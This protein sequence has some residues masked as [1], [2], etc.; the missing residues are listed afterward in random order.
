MQPEALVRRDLSVCR[1]WVVR[2]P[3]GY[4]MYFTWSVKDPEAAIPSG[5]RILAAF[6]R[7]LVRW[8]VDERSLVEPFDGRNYLAS[9]C[10]E[11]IPGGYRMYFTASR[12]MR[13]CDAIYVAESED[14]LRFGGEFR[15]VM[16]PAAGKPYARGCF[17]PFVTGSG[18]ARR[19]LFAGYGVDRRPQICVADG[20]GEWDFWD[21]RLLMGGFNHPD[22]SYG[23]YK[24]V[25]FE[26]W[27]YFVGK[28]AEERGSVYRMPC[29]EF[30]L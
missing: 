25:L 12:K 18:E 1:P 9:P 23:P 30:G 4:R 27:M 16:A 6:S 13:C 15:E 29:S 22:I 10:V 21:G 26:G 11:E 2:V 3:G 17:T 20:Y 19:L 28:D 5:F 7:D 8:E 14:G 24:A